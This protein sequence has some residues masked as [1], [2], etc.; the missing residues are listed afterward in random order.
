MQPN[1]FIWII[2]L[3]S[4]FLI[5]IRPFKL[6]EAY[7]AV[8]GA[9]VLLVF[10][11]ISAA[12]VFEGIKKGLD[13]YLFL[14]G[15]MLLAEVARE[16]KLF[17]WLAAVA[18][19]YSKGSP[20][21]LFLLVYSVGIIITVFLS[22]DATA[23]VLTPA[24][25]AGAKAAKIENPLPFLL[26]CAFIANAASFV[27]PISNP[28]NLV[29]YGKN[30]PALFSWLRQYVVPS[31]IS[32]AV[33]YLCL[34]FTQRKSLQST[35]DTDI[36][37]PTLSTGGRLAGLGIIIS[38]IVLMVCSAFDVA[39]GLPTA[40]TGVAVF[41]IVVIYCKLQPLK[42]LSQISWTVLPMVAGLFV[43]V[44]GLNKTGVIALTKSWLI[45]SAGRSTIF[46]TWSSGIGVAVMSNVMNNLPSGLIAGNAVH[47]A[48]IPSIVQRAILIGV[49][50]GPNLSVTGSLATILW[51]VVLRREGETISVWQFLKLGFVVMFPA[52]LLS[53]LSLWI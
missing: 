25:F 26:I 42:V 48:G 13:V 35:I 47:T 4:I 9:V 50:L 24:V 44:E 21:R 1:I 36:S 41:C 14:A 12:D 19:S 15:M 34:F 45:K 49:D 30:M 43:I 11:L 8:G 53:I 51:L 6:P 10:G 39:L 23:V 28:A 7:W 40:I 32:I 3:L 5:I 29:I 20:K 38:A 2:A 16:E 17:D 33:T 37:L 27:L 52:L 22:N 31:L 18:V 46:T